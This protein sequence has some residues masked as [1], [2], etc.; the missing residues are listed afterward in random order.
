MLVLEYGVNA[1]GEMARLLSIAKP[2]LACI[3]ALTPV[4]LE[5]MGSLEVIVREKILL[6]AAAPPRMGPTWTA[7]A[8]ARPA[9]PP[10][11]QSPGGP[12]P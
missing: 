9:A 6:A 3:T 10:C 1:P 11:A 2:Q 5:G 12:W 4:H 8:E 7:A